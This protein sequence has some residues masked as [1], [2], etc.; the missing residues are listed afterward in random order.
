MNYEIQAWMVVLVIGIL[1]GTIILATWIVATENGY[2]K[3][4]K[5]GYDRGV[6]DGTKRTMHTSKITLQYPALNNDFV[7][8][9]EKRNE[10]LREDNDY[11]ME[12]V[13]SLWDKENR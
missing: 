2:D 10:Q 13:V 9:L 3:G 6:Y 5:S 12:K 11:L 1:V 4:F 8:P 7:I